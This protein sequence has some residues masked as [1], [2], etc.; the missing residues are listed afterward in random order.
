MA[1]V[2]YRIEL[3]Q[4]E[5]KGLNALHY[6]WVKTRVTKDPTNPDKSKREIITV[7][8]EIHGFPHD[9]EMGRFRTF[10]MGGDDLRMK[11]KDGPTEHFGPS[12]RLPRVVA[13]EK[14]NREEID[15]R[16][17]AGLTRGSL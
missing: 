16:W 12:Q 11:N 10:S 5:V 4:I 13:I 7:L 2:T 14:S 9:R 17:N 1:E 8:G 3:R 15:K 6:F